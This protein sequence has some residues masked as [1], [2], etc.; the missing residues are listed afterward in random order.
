MGW[1]LLAPAVLEKVLKA[2][3]SPQEVAIVLP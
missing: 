2:L 3:L 1:I